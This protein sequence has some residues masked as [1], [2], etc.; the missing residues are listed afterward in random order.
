[1][2]TAKDSVSPVGC[3]NGY[4]WVRVLAMSSDLLPSLERR[5]RRFA[6][7]ARRT[8]FATTTSADRCGHFWIQLRS[9][10]GSVTTTFGELWLTILKDACYELASAVASDCAGL[11][12]RYDNST[13]FE[14][15]GGSILPNFEFA[16]AASLA[17]ADTA[18]VS[19]YV[20]ASNLN[21]IIARCEETG[22]SVFFF[23]SQPAVI[24]ALRDKVVSSFPALTIAGVCDADFRGPISRDI[25]DH[26]AQARPDMIITDMSAQCFAQFSCSGDERFKHAL[27]S[28]VP[29]AFRQFVRAGRAMAWIERPSAGRGLTSFLQAGLSSSRFLAIVVGQSLLT[30]LPALRLSRT[31]QTARR[32]R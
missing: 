16:P 25:M 22:L 10:G 8:F 32:N 3:K 5:G 21:S 17:D 19:G 13:A 6:T 7:S 11:G 15:I 9:G 14:P 4:C 24:Y 1:M 2:Q 23:G 29:G 28:N 26:I 20:R 31:G 27:L 30:L 12:R 18:S